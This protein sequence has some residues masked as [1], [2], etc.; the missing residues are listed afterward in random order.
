M[1]RIVHDVSYRKGV[2]ISTAI[3][4]VVFFFL[5]DKKQV[6]TLY[7]K[8]LK[9]A[10]GCSESLPKLSPGVVFFS[11]CPA[12]QPIIYNLF[13]RQDLCSHSVDRLHC[14][15]LTCLHQSTPRSIHPVIIAS[16]LGYRFTSRYIY[17]RL[18]PDTCHAINMNAGSGGLAANLT[19]RYYRQYTS[20]GKKGHFLSLD[21]PENIFFFFVMTAQS[22]CLLMR[23]AQ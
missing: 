18:A 3:A 6:L 20:P 5:F 21:L 8:R 7:L 17:S 22:W 9:P 14:L 10:N 1:A 2:G 19:T 16:P 12:S 15:P 23:Q 13:L 4:S 11:C